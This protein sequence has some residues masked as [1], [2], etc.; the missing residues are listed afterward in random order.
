MAESA[1]AN[2]KSHS[3]ML[4]SNKLK[5]LAMVPGLRRLSFLSKILCPTVPVVI[6]L[7]LPNRKTET[8]T[9]A[10]ITH[11]E[12]SQKCALISRSSNLSPSV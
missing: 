9:R 2:Y 4:D 1:L 11:E 7:Q 5:L 3:G 10:I 12:W 8:E 6:N